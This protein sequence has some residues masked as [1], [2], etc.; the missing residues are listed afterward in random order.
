[1]ESDSE[2]ERP[3]NGWNKKFEK[4]IKDFIA[5]G[6]VELTAHSYLA[7]KYKKQDFLLNVFVFSL[8]G[9]A[10]ISGDLN[11]RYE[12]N[13]FYWINLLLGALSLGIKGFQSWYNASEKRIGHITA[14]GQKSASIGK[15]KI[16][17]NLDPEN[18]EDAEDFT[19]WITSEYGMISG[20]TAYIDPS[21]LFKFTKKDKKND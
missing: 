7:E 5:S 12:H 13:V 20:S 6:E 4:T 8:M 17:L 9:A 10:F 3:N 2:S 21:T 19:N 14:Q 15:A 1:M 11:T 16:Q 18:R